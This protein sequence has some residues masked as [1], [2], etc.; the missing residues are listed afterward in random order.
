M[1]KVVVK[2]SGFFVDI[3]GVGSFRSPF[4]ITVPD[5]LKSLVETSLLK[6]GIRDFKVFAIDSFEKKEEIKIMEEI[7]YPEQKPTVDISEVLIRLEDIQLLV[8]E[9]LKRDNIIRE[10][11]IQKESAPVITK[12]PEIEEDIFIPT[13]SEKISVMDLSVK[14]A[15]KDDISD[16][17]ESL[18]NLKKRRR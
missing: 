3:P 5:S 1:V 8:N 10:V 11:I 18:L 16:Q 15:G 2:Q 17:V 12:Q 13:F 6:N 7:K 9:V 14:T 4:K